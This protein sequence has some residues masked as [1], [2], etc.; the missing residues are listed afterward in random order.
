MLMQG[1]QEMGNDSFYKSGGG[2]ERWM[3]RELSFVTDAR[4]KTYPEA[5]SRIVM[6]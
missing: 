5:H 3:I 6:E 4:I 2:I 1:C